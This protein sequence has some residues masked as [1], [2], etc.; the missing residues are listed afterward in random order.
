METSHS[1]AA[2]LIALLLL[3]A[4]VVVFRVK[5]VWFVST[6]HKL[7][8]IGIHLAST[9]KLIWVLPSLPDKQ[10]ADEAEIERLLVREQQ[11]ATVEQENVSLRAL[12]GVATPPKI[13]RI[14]GQVIGS[15][16]GSFGSR[17][18]GFFPE[19]VLLTAGEPVFVNGV[20]FGIITVGQPTIIEP[21]TS[22]RIA[23]AVTIGET[24]LVGLLRGQGG[25]ILVEDINSTEPISAGSEIRVAAGDL[26]FPVGTP[27]GRVAR[28]TTEPGSLLR[29]VTATPYQNPLETLFVEIYHQP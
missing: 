17:L 29:R 16:P 26:T 10:A 27:I 11:L 12:L 2:R 8:M 15:V 23:V 24:K 25:S 28:D 5:P 4:L 14:V 21:L 20:A 3:A 7:R 19:N 18:I 9:G 6:G 1:S 22:T 13:N